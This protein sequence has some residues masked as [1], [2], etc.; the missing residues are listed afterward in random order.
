MMP[1]R[2]LARSVTAFAAVAALTLTACGPEEDAEFEENGNGE[3]T[4]QTS[5]TEETD[6]NDDD[7]ADDEDD[8]G[9]FGDE[10]DE[11]DSA[12]EDDD[13][14]E[15]E[16][17]DEETSTSEY[18]LDADAAV[19]TVTFDIPNQDIDGTMT[20]GF[21]HLRVEESAMELMLSITADH[22]QHD[23]F[24]LGGLLDQ[25]YPHPVLNDKENLKRY[26][27]LSSSVYA[28][29]AWATSTGSGGMEFPDGEP[30]F[31][32]GM[33]PVPEDDIDELT[34]SMVSTVPELEGVTIDWGDH[35]P[36]DDVEADEDEEAEED[37]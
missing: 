30:Q 33:Y 16:D 15:Q 21:H 12:S 17:E 11:D 25:S 14:D 27:P 24:S 10:D 5:D 13:E 1:R 20:V 19:E 34:I 22:G 26:T 36:S 4:E 8:D 31:Y 7:S 18:D 6:D 29:D 37:E 9:Y 3:E 35:G 32:W 28:F 23:T 2:N